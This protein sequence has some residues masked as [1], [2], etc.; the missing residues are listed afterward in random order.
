MSLQDDIAQRLR[1]EFP[2]HDFNKMSDRL[3]SAS[4]TPRIQR[5]IV[6]ASRGNS[7]YF[8]YLCDLA[9][10]DYRDVI[11]AG[12]YDRFDIQLYD[13]NLPFDQA[14]IPAPYGARTI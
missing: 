8:D 13:F 2:G 4:S 1:D 7:E 5:C 14:K 10:S 12:E 6:F 9:K 11:M 3:S